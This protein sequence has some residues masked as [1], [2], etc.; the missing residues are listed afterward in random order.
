MLDAEELARADR[1]RFVSD[2]DTFTAAHALARAMPTA[3]WRYVEGKFVMPALAG[4]LR[5]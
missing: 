2:R 4:R 5:G 3:T 1:Y